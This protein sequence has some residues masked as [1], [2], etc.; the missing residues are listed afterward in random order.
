MPASARNTKTLPAT[1]SD[2]EN[3][4]ISTSNE[5][6]LFPVRKRNAQ[7]NYRGRIAPSGHGKSTT[8]TSST[9]SVVRKRR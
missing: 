7:A 4:S 8:H 9:E 3:A 1:A 2:G 6:S 5:T